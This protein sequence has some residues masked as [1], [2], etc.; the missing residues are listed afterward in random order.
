VDNQNQ[1]NIPID[2]QHLPA[3]MYLLS[4]R[5]SAQATPQILKLI[6]IY[7]HEVWTTFLDF[8]CII[9]DEGAA[10]LFQVI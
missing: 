7:A 4:V 2:V 8:I 6:K 3:G 5:N 9:W 10:L 1:N